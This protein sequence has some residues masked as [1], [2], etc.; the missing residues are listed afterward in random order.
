[1]DKVL[2]YNPPL[3]P[4]IYLNNLDN[5][6]ER[7]SRRGSF[8]ERNRQWFRLGDNIYYSWWDWYNWTYWKLV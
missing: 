5:S 3:T 8:M 2:F 4:E 1:M 7:L 6:S